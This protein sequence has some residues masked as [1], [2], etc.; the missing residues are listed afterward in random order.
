[1]L[2]SIPVH[3]Y[4]ASCPCL[5]LN[6]FEWPKEKRKR[7]DLKW[8][9]LEL[10]LST[11]DFQNAIKTNEHLSMYTFVCKASDIIWIVP[12]ENSHNYLG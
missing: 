11:S 6:G 4:Q 9:I 7:S 1:M 5:G 8:C 2:P 3:L 12:Y 10:F